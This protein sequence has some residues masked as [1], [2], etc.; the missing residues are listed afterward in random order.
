MEVFNELNDAMSYHD[1]STFPNWHAIRSHLCR[2]RRDFL[3]SHYRR[4]SDQTPPDGP[5]PSY[6]EAIGQEFFT[7]NAASF[8]LTNRTGRLN[9]PS[10][11]VGSFRSVA[12]SVPLTTT[13]TGAPNPDDRLTVLSQLGSN[14]P[15]RRHG[16]S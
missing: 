2:T 6:E 12:G 3:R 4:R 8:D 11:D 15:Y 9:D 5:P 7:S 10:A 13:N 14:N 1:E 16:R